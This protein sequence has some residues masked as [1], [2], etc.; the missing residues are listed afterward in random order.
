[1]YNPSL[2]SEHM[3]RVTHV[4][5]ARRAS[6][7]HCFE[8]RRWQSWSVAR[9]RRVTLGTPVHHSKASLFCWFLLM[10]TAWNA[11]PLQLSVHEGGTILSPSG[12]HCVVFSAA[13]VSFRDMLRDTLS[14][15]DAANRL[16]S[17]KVTAAAVG[18]VSP[19]WVPVVN[20]DSSAQP[21]ITGLHIKAVHFN[22]RPLAQ[23]ALYYSQRA[24]W[25]A[26]A[27]HNCTPLGGCCTLRRQSPSRGI[28]CT[29]EIGAPLYRV[30]ASRTLL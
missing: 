24:L 20:P 7:S 18:A 2:P 22:L 17:V 14:L 27:V 5:G 19:N 21:M 4:T 8:I 9:R 30:V 12:L 23:T 6:K 15:P 11:L 29:R 26:T 25:L 3:R 10:A 1:M 13:T 16:E 28:C